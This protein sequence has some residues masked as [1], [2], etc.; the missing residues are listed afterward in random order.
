MLYAAQAE[1]EVALNSFRDEFKGATDIPHITSMQI[2][3][4][5][6]PFPYFQ[7][8]NTTKSDRSEPSDFNGII[9]HIVQTISGRARGIARAREQDVHCGDGIT[10][11]ARDSLAGNP[12]NGPDSD[13]RSVER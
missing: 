3:T 12:A 4:H 6:L 7:K 11:Y 2:S 1:P 8:T 13:R 9:L 10:D 5:L